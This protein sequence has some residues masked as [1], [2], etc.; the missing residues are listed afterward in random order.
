MDGAS[1]PWVPEDSFVT[2]YELLYLCPMITGT[3]RMYRYRLSV[4]RTD[5]RDVEI[6]VNRVISL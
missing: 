6:A 3:L 2:M 5:M 4:F 1:S